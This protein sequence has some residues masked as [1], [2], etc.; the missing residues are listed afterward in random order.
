MKKLAIFDLDG[1]LLDTLED[2]KNS[3]NYALSANGLPE[4]SLDE[5]RRFVGNGIRLLIERAVPQGTA[6]ELTDAVFADFKAHYS[7]HS[8]D[9]TAPYAGIAELLAELKSEG[10]LLGVVSNKADAP[11]K[12]LIRHYFP[13][14]FDS[15]VGEREGVRKKP[16]PDSVLETMSELDCKAEDCVYIG[17][18]DVDFMTAKNAGCDCILVSWGFRSRQQLEVLGADKIADSVDSLV[19][20]LFA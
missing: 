11:A 18:S 19:K 9:T 17:D 14:T 6:A 1:T 12:A 2:L 3:V 10:R 20:M 16:A 8:M 4:R 15:V 5:V 13:D 7:A